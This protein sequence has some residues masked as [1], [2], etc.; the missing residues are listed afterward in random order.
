MK[1]RRVKIAEKIM[2]ENWKWKNK[3]LKK[4]KGKIER[5]TEEKLEE[6]ESGNWMELRVKIGW[7]IKKE[8]W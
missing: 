5:K 8:Y 4:E 1:I 7:K 3:N 6:K 2:W